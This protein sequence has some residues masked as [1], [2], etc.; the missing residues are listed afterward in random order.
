[1]TA[2]DLIL[3]NG[4]VV[5]V[6]QNNRVYKWIAVKDKKIIDLGDD[7]RYKEYMLKANETLNLM[8]KTV[9]PGFYDSHVHLVQTGLN[10]MA[11]DLSDV[12]SIKELME[13]IENTAKSLPDGALIRGIRFDES[14][15]KEGRMPTRRELDICSPNNPVWVNRI[16]Y[17]TSVVNSLALHMI[18][19]PFNLEGIIRGEDNLPNGMLTGKASAMVRNQIF[20]LI[21]NDVRGNGV[22]KALSTAV[23]NGI[24]TINAMEGGFS[25]HDKDAEFILENSET[26]PID[27]ILFYQTVNLNKVL[28]RNLSRIGGCIFL[29]G[30]FGSRT[31]AV[32][33]AYADD[34]SNYGNLYFSQDELNDFV[35]N[36]HK[37]NLQIAVH[38]IGGRAIEQILNAY[39][40]A[41]MMDYKQDCRHRIEHFEIPTDEQIERAKQL[42]VYLSMQP[43]YEYHWGGAGGMYQK[44]L[45][46][47]KSKKT[48]PFKKIVD[49][50]LI[51]AGGSDSDV[52]QMNPLLGIHTAVNHPNEEFAVDALDAVK[53]FTING[54]KAVFEEHIK[55]SLEK[56]KYADFVIL[57]KDP[58]T[59]NKNEIKDIAIVATIKEGKILYMN[60]SVVNEDEA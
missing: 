23:V 28:S 49:K 1:M 51:I 8:G 30:S 35:I 56:G 13:K 34:P 44:R 58:I 10:L 55:G 16:E 3:Y 26:F 6:D 38:A 41:Q 36:A 5:T 33:E 14:K 4:N 45:G 46:L 15:I 43:A 57:D 52:T 19:L 39:E 47:E 2:I 31:A 50:G 18:N 25:F 22:N 48:N 59:V 7:D 21:G 32:S 12:K 9:F 60:R 42:N 11:L 24:T 17:H 29:D 20:G 37:N 53:L 54:A 27:V 40:Y